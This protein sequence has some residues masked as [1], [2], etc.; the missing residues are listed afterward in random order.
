MSVKVPVYKMDG[1]TSG[2]MELD[3]KIFEVKVN[4]ALIQQ[5]VVAQQANS[6]VAIA[7]TKTRGEVRGG[8]KKPW[9][10]KGTGRA[11]HGSIRSPIWKGGG[12]TFGPRSERN[13]SLNMNAKAKQRALFMTLSDKAHNGKLIVLESLELP[14][15]QTKAIANMLK[16]LK[17]N[18]TVLTVLMKQDPTLWKSARNLPKV[19]TAPVNSLNV[20]DVLQHDT[21]LIP[22]AAVEALGKIYK[23]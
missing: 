16:S 3:P 21:L 4:G 12:V 18:K 2:E 19:T 6:R 5:A 9:R 17:L 1:T 8:G 10:Q 20:V 23:R 7:H 11:R 15:I 22:K 13:F 14:K